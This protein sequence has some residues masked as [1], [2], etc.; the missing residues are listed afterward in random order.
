MSTP[1][2]IEK[3]P[4]WLFVMVAGMLG[5]FVRAAADLAASAHPGPSFLVSAWSTWLVNLAGAALLGWVS[6]TLDSR[7]PSPASARARFFFATGLCG[8][9]TTY[10]TLLLATTRALLVH[11]VAALVQTL[12]MLALGVAVG[13]F[14]WRLARRRA[15]RRASTPG[16]RVD[17][18]GGN[19]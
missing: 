18:G 2:R 3:L 13:A 5:T 7:V 17:A 10:S 16:R 15:L 6:A 1:A 12:L 9:L 4:A 14:T 8:A 19:A 11:P